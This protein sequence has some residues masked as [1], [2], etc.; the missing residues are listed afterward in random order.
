MQ[1]FLDKRTSESAI[2]QDDVVET[3]FLENVSDFFID[4]RSLTKP[5]KPDAISISARTAPISP[6][7]KTSRPNEVERYY[8]NIQLSN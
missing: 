8:S 6:T 2:P 4:I 3:A 7:V 5:K 1:G